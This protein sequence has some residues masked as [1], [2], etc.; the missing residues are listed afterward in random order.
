MNT[1]KLII[2]TAIISLSLVGCAQ[3]R[4]YRP[5]VDSYSQGYP[6]Q[7]YRYPQ[8]GYPQ[9]QYGYQNQGYPQQQYGGYPQP[10]QNN[11]YEMQ[12]AYAECEQLA[13]QSSN[14][15]GEIIQ[16][17]LVGGALGAAAGAAIGAINGNAGRG[18]M[19]GSTA[20]IAGAG[21][22]MYKSDEAYKRSYDSCMRNRGFNV[23]R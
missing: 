13:S 6:T 11:A 1:K 22:G 7:Q 8:Q 3:Q 2:T 15:T 18:A 9:Q 10:Q 16:D 19:Y 23:I 21:Y 12:R 17:T 5:T 14:Q 20:G 4:G